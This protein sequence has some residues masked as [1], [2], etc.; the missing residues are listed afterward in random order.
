MGFKEHPDGKSK[1]TPSDHLLVG[2]KIFNNSDIHKK[3][4]IDTGFSLLTLML[5]KNHDNVVL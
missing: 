2:V 5:H 3:T 1:W 4:L